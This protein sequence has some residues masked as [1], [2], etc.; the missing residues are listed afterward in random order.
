MGR[1]LVVLETHIHPQLQTY[2]RPET[3]S[4]S[5]KSSKARLQTRKPQF[6]SS[7]GHTLRLPAS[8]EPLGHMEKGKWA[9]KEGL[10]GT[11]VPGLVAFCSP[12]RIGHHSR[13]LL[14]AHSAASVIRALSP[15]SGAGFWI[16]ATRS[17]ALCMTPKP[18]L[19]PSANWVQ[20][21]AD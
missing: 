4:S 17:R 12:Y 19:V 9:P 1:S 13:P 18:S 6:D 2:W 14:A 21:L 5:S 16:L 11:P 20:G 8:G 7:N 3:V 15:S 10:Q